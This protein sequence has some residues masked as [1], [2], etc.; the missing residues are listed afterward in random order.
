MCPLQALA[1]AA[2]KRTEDAFPD[3]G[4]RSCLTSGRVTW[5]SDR[6]ARERSLLGG[7]WREKPVGLSQPAGLPGPS[8]PPPPCSVQLGSSALVFERHEQSVPS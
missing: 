4:A 2:C 8:P 6:R 5:I 7:G 1:E 3:S